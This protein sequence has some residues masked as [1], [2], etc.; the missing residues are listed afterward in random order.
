MSSSESDSE[1]SSVLSLSNPPVP[2][3]KSTSRTSASGAAKPIGK[4]SPR[5]ESTRPE[6]TRPESTKPSTSVML[7]ARA[8]QLEMLEESLKGNIIVA[9]DTGSG[10]TQVA[11]LRIEK[12]LERVSSEKIVWFLAPTVELCRQQHL[13]IQ[14]QIQSIQVKIISS[15]VG[16][17]TWSSQAVWDAVLRNVRV[18]VATYQI[19]LDALSHGFVKLC[20]IPL[21]IIDEAHNCKSNNPGARLMKDHYRPKKDAGQ[22]VPS[23]LGLT[24]SPIL[25]SK[26]EEIAILEGILDAKCKTPHVHRDELACYVNCPTLSHV[27]YSPNTD[28]TFTPTLKS[29]RVL[30]SLDILDDPYIKRLRLDSSDRGRRALEKAVFGEDTWCRQT[31]R[32]LIRKSQTIYTELGAWAAD[33]FVSEVVRCCTKVHAKAFAD[34]LGEERQYLAD[35]LRQVELPKSLDLESYAKTYPRAISDKMER[36]LRVLD[37]SPDCTIGIIFVKERATTI[38]LERLISTVPIFEGK[39]RVGSM[40]GLSSFAAR[41]DVSELLRSGKSNSLHQFRCGKINLLVATS[42]LE[43]GIDVPACNLVIC[44]DEPQN[45]KS[46]IQRRGRARMRESRL[47]VMNNGISQSHWENLEKTMKRQYQDQE[48]EIQR[49]SEI[50]DSEEADFPPYVVESTNARLEINQAISHLEHFCSRLSSHRYAATRPEYITQHV[51]RYREDGAPMMKAVVELPIFVPQHL[52]AAQSTREWAAEKNAFKEAAFQAYVNLHGAGLVNDNLLPAD[53]FDFT[54]KIEYRDSFAI[55]REQYN[56]WRDVAHAWNQKLDVT[57]YPIRFH[58]VA[59]NAEANFVMSLPARI[60]QTTPVPL[61]FSP[62]TEFNCEIGSPDG[63][64]NT[65]MDFDDHTLELLSLAFA[66]RWKVKKSRHVVQFHSRLPLSTEQLGALPLDSSGLNGPIPMD[67]LIRDPQNLSYYYQDI[68]N[69]K[70]DRAQVNKRYYGFDEA[71]A[72]VPYVICKRFQKRIGLQRPSQQPAKPS[73]R[74]PSA[75]ALPDCRVDAVP[76]VYAQFGLAIPAILRHSEVLL[77]ASYLSE[78]LLRNVGIRSTK[79]L[80][81]AICASSA[82]EKTNYQKLE[83]LGDTVLKLFTSVNCA[84]DSEY[85]SSYSPMPHD[86][87]EPANLAAEPNFPEGFLSKTKDHFV[88]NAHLCRATVESGLDQ[89]IITEAFRYHKW[90]PF[91]VDDLLST[92]PSSTREMSTKMLAD[93]MESL[94]GASYV[95]GGFNKG[96]AC[97]KAFLKSNKLEWR[98]LDQCANILF[99]L[100]PLD[101]DLPPDHKALE[102]LLSYKFQR[103]SILLEAVTHSSFNRRDSTGSLDRLEF[104]GDAIL[105]SIV[106]KHLY[107]ATAGPTREQ[108]SL[109][110]LH[111]MRTALVNADILGFLC[112][113]STVAQAKTTI[114]PSAPSYSFRKG[115]PEAIKD[116]ARVVRDETE[117]KPLWKFLRIGSP[118][119]VY[120]QQAMVERHRKIRDSISRELT[121]GKRYPWHLLCTMQIPKFYSDMVEAI[122]GAV[123]VDSGS[124]DIVD[125]VIERLGLLNIMRRILEDG[126]NTTHPKVQVGIL[127]RQK[128]VRYDVWVLHEDGTTTLAPGTDDGEGSEEGGSSQYETASEGYGGEAAVPVVDAEENGEIDGASEL[129][130]QPEGAAWKE[131]HCRLFVGDQCRMAVSGGVSREEVKIKAALAAVTQWDP[132]WALNDDEDKEKHKN[133]DEDTA[134][135]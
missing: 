25:G 33:R 125:G 56:P 75:I 39:F 14:N 119:L 84:A 41:Q 96:L 93:V 42:V 127:A 132:R 113:E 38:M 68:V 19:L 2:D 73:S 108:L 79:L 15:L 117:K 30:L 111:E 29:L 126:V 28:T 104:I 1:S 105:D 37:K 48:R 116:P 114:L 46:F 109:E 90:R 44:F 120:I 110:K 35:N 58:D 49:L 69:Y 11:V 57:Y 31:V 65:K 99:H 76:S 60:P 123:W 34:L 101:I 16:V 66:S 91:Y 59:G 85:H 82:G 71:P 67:A 43:E 12:E 64:D 133:E 8:Y 70:P 128:K 32:A 121:V 61:Y 83:F 106:V 55:V 9:M 107:N 53:A 18:V 102:E 95:E 47:V 135:K 45:L 94:I 118:E 89:F 54:G 72:D 24:A 4:D 23:I 78:T 27:S 7:N 97:I 134:S 98:T 80:A 22:A 17:D 26:I 21:I 87:W 92:S 88:S 86:G 100:A 63:I 52:R 74:H 103:K 20:N 62:N 6:S 115:M 124:L 51:G 50:E 5:P 81:T 13:V 112:M 36:L 40:V 131:F 10:K 3:S 122:I 77:V 129:S 130:S